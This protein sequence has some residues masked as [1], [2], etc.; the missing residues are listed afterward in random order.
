MCNNSGIHGSSS[1]SCI[2][3][4]HVVVSSLVIVLCTHTQKS[5]VS[6]DFVDNDDDVMPRRSRDNHG[7][8]CAGIVAMV[9]SNGVCGVGVAHESQIAGTASIVHVIS[10]VYNNI[11][12]SPSLR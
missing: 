9:K 10:H 12:I 5:E 8:S 6:W 11:S 2:S 3:K 1:F 7:T 4:P